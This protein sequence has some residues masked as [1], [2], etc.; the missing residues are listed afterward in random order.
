MKATLRLKFF[1]WIALHTAIVFLVI[2][3]VFVSFSLHELRAYPEMVDSEI[4]EIRT[5]VGVAAMLVPLSLLS[6]W[7]ISRRLLRPLQRIIEPAERIGSGSLKERIV[8][9]V[10]DDEIGRLAQTLNRAFDRYQDSLQRLKRFSFD[11]SHQLRNPLAALRARGE[12]CLQKP[13]TREEYEE[14]IGS[15]LESCQRLSHTVEQLLMLANT[16]GG[17]PPHLLAP[18]SLPLLLSSAHNDA[19]PVAEMKRIE[20]NTRIDESTAPVQGIEDMLREAVANLLDNALKHTPEGGR[21]RISLESPEPQ[22][23]RICVDDSGPGVPSEQRGTLFRAFKRGAMP[24]REGV[25]LGLAIV[26]DIAAAHAGKVG[27]DTSDLG[28]SRFWIEL[29]TQAR[30]GLTPP[31]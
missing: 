2:G 16:A 23:A 18:V 30:A 1:L 21:I 4:R 10:D 26:A 28:G 15:M 14:T 22:R 5:M 12:V 20:L 3:V 17:L 13:R 29:P 31:R 9:P 24:S 25:G 6:A 11:A 27:I 8:A 19:L 7:L